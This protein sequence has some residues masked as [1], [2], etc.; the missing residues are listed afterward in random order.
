MDLAC[1][2]GT[3]AIG[4]DDDARSDCEALV[5]VTTRYPP[6]LIRPRGR[7]DR[8]HAS[9]RQDLR[10]SALCLS[11]KCRVQTGAGNCKRNVDARVTRDV[12]E[13]ALERGA[14]G[15]NDSPP[16]ECGGIFVQDNL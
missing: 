9:V 12:V 10:A 16:G 7:L 1:D 6:R 11:E 2:D 4:A 3:K 5:V 14:P 13:A 8:S 15:R